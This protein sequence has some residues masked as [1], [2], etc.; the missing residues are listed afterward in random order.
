MKPDSSTN[1]LNASRALD[2]LRAAVKY[3]DRGREVFFDSAVPD[4]FL[5]V[6]GELRKA[7]ESLNRLGRS[8]YRANPKLDRDRIG[9]IRQRLTHDYVDVD[10]GFIWKVATEEAPGVIHLLT[11]A[12][13]PR[14]E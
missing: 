2:H 7:Y 8:F 11:R 9:E 1:Q 4:T 14:S 13:M 10:P 12:K 3:A 5:L 6:E